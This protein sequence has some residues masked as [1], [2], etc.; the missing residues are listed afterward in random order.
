M[1]KHFTI[2]IYI[3]N[4]IIGSLI[5]ESFE[6]A[7]SNKRLVKINRQYNKLQRRNYVYSFKE[8]NF[9]FALKYILYDKKVVR[10]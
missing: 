5:N 3:E 1:Q 2:W 9:I 6:S 7:E 8:V 10:K 4:V